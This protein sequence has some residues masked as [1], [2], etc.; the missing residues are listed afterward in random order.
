MHI[1]RVCSV[2]CPS[3]TAQIAHVINAHPNGERL[4]M[5]HGF[6]MEPRGKAQE[7][8][9]QEHQLDKHPCEFCS[10]T[11]ARRNYLTRHIRTIHHFSVAGRG[12]P[13]C[14]LEP[15][16]EK[17]DVEPSGVDEKEPKQEDVQHKHQCKSCSKT[18]A[19]RSYLTR[20]TR[21]VHHYS[22]AIAV[23]PSRKTENYII[24]SS[25]MNAMSKKGSPESD[26]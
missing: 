26:A 7:D 11:F 25:G 18:F 1:C 19:R 21:R 17:Q 3:A 14:S 24:K 4:A 2:V 16:K 15:V 12:L 10:K 22:M 23:F 13:K 20:H 5:L 6:K 9:V 8:F